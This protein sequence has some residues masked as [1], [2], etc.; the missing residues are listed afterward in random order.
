MPALGRKVI[1][2][3]FSIISIPYFPS[4]LGVTGVLPSNRSYSLDMTPVH[5][6]ATNAGGKKPQKTFDQKL[7]E[8]STCKLAKAIN[9]LTSDASRHHQSGHSDS[10]SPRIYPQ[11]HRK[12]VCSNWRAGSNLGFVVPPK[13]MLRL[14]RA[15]PC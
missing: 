9:K 10:Q 14:K 12:K 11:T 7:L 13:N 8:S 6:E 4:P 2:M 5:R 3:Y 1:Q 15:T